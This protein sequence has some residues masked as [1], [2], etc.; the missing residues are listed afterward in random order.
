MI[1]GL[2]VPKPLFSSPFHS[3]IESDSSSPFTT[4]SS[5]KLFSEN[6]PKSKQNILA[7]GLWPST[8]PCISHQHHHG[9]RGWSLRSSPKKLERVS[10][11]WGRPGE[12]WRCLSVWNRVQWVHEFVEFCYWQLTTFQLHKVANISLTIEFFFNVL[13]L[14]IKLSKQVPLDKFFHLDICSKTT[15]CPAFRNPWRSEPL[16]DVE[17][18]VFGFSSQ[19]L[20][21]H[22][23]IQN[24]QEKDQKDFEWVLKGRDLFSILL[25]YFQNSFN[26]LWERLMQCHPTTRWMV[27]SKVGGMPLG[28]VVQVDVSGSQSQGHRFTDMLWFQSIFILAVH[29]RVSPWLYGILGYLPT[30]QIYFSC[31]I[32]GLISSTNCNLAIGLQSTWRYIHMVLS[33]H[34]SQF[35]FLPW[36]EIMNLFRTFRSQIFKSHPS[37]LKYFLYIPSR[38]PSNWWS[39]LHLSFGIESFGGWPFAKDMSLHVVALWVEE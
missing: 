15:R 20:S 31:Q 8:V 32:F 3:E 1:W 2:V 17:F 26:Y 9:H 4:I 33:V 7:F 35:L 36:I 29:V 30:L 27:W 13:E 28:Q 18:K 25:Q 22:A 38:P 23:V 10:D 21:S 39:L 24:S 12:F 16:E 6:P 5:P 11:R 14:A 19:I 37:G 34:T